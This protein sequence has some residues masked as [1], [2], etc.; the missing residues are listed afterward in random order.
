M[1]YWSGSPSSNNN[2]GSSA[3]CV[4]FQ[5]DGLSSGVECEGR[6]H[7]KYNI[8]IRLFS[9][10]ARF[11]ASFHMCDFL[12][13]FNNRFLIF[14]CSF[15]SYKR[16]FLNCFLHFV[17]RKSIFFVWS[18]LLIYCFLWQPNFIECWEPAVMFYLG[19]WRDLSQDFTELLKY[20]KY[21]TGR[22]SVQK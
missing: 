1:P 9:N 2:I 19:L 6:A 13:G 3:Y 10:S 18:T 4:A 22:S 5:G 15:C 8:R 14:L 20:L 17:N 11:Q 7:L 12:Q 16:M 21:L